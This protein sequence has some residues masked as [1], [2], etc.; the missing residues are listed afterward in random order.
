MRA[1]AG[2]LTRRHELHARREIL[3]RA[4]RLEAQA[5]E[6]SEDLERHRASAELYRRAL[7]R[8]RF[9]QDERASRRGAECTER[10]LLAYARD[11][12]CELQVQRASAE[13][14]ET[15]PSCGNCLQ[16]VANVSMLACGHCGLSRFVLDCQ[17]SSSCARDDF[18]ET[19]I[20]TK[21][22]A[23]WVDFL[24]SAQARSSCSVPE[25]VVALVSER[26]G[27]A[28]SVTPLLVREALKALGYSRY[29]S[30]AP[31]LA[32]MISGAQPPCMSPLEEE[33]LRLM[34]VRACTSF[35]HC[36]A[37]GTTQ[38]TNFLPY[39]YIAR[40]LCELLGLQHMIPWLAQLRAAVKVDRSDVI[41]RCICEDVPWPFVPTDPG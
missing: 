25:A 15:C 24:R 40:K 5:G 30:S 38:R 27:G 31:S 18:I 11:E 22:V 39:P 36:V 28:A 29:Y 17:S 1:R 16:L 37:R 21:R 12:A 26:L 33:K 14:A 41:W 8:A 35:Q 3:E 6:A 13:D 20:T 19:S 4:E 32:A 2:A 7:S 10:I 9:L 23:H 34:F